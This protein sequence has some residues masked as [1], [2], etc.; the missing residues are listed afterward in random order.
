MSTT[1]NP[2]GHRAWPA[3]V[4][5]MALVLAACGGSGDDETQVATLSGDDAAA[6]D[7]GTGDA[8]GAEVDTSEALLEYAACMRE[9]GVDMEDPT[10]DAD[11]N[12]Q[13]GGFGGG[14]GGDQGFDPR[15]DEFQTAQEACGDLLEGVTFGGPGGGGGFD[16]SAIQDALTSFTQCLRDEGIQVDDV[17][18]GGPGGGA[19]GGP[20]ADGEA[21]EGGPGGGFAGTPPGDGEAPEGGPGG[22]GFDP[23]DRIIEQLDL[24][25]EDP[26]VQA[27]LE[28]CQPELESAFSQQ[29][30]DAAASE[31]Q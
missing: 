30:D 13:G 14:A 9:N 31:D 11:G 6:S 28:V 4:A 5:T 16:G 19:D 3:L 27:A 12:L 25:D 17:T 18:L 2:A 10:F 23:S 24:D 8:E 7:D 29:A 26:A 21:P 22:G 20:P 1:T 15:S